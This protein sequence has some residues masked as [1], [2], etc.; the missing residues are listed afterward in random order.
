MLKK[1]S[2]NF[3]KMKNNYKQRELELKFDMSKRLSEKH[4]AKKPAED[5]AFFKKAKSVNELLKL[6]MKVWLTSKEAD[7]EYILLG[8]P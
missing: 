5:K 2:T 3:N 7:D 1:A 6:R 8:D 4:K